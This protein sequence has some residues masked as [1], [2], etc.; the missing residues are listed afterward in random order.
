MKNSSE[1]NSS[2][3]LL[4]QIQI[5]NLQFPACYKDVNYIIPFAAPTFVSEPC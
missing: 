5:S 3:T 4:F 1:L 2:L